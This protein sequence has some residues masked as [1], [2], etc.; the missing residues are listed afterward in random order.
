MFWVI[1][2]YFNIRN[3]L[4]KSGTFLLGHPVCKLLQIYKHCLLRKSH[5]P[6][7]SHLESYFHQQSPILEVTLTTDPPSQKLNSPMMSHFKSYI[8]PTIPHL[9]SYTCQQS[10]SQ[11]LTLPTMSHLNSYIHQQ[12]LTFKVTLTNIPPPLRS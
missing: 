3:T 9:R 12:P 8:Y 7:M 2:V 1:S 10:P 4:P 11:R 5:L 6:T